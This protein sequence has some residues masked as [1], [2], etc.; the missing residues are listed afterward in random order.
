MDHSETVKRHFIQAREAFF[1]LTIKFY[2]TNYLIHYVQVT[3][4]NYEDDT[5]EC[6]R[7]CQLRS[8]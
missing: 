8:H 6:K 5:T 4:R 1:V 2:E 3:L 7:P